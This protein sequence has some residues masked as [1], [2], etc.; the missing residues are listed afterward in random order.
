MGHFG[1]IASL[2][3]LPNEKTLI[4]YV[5]K[6][7]ELNKKGIKKPDEFKPKKKPPLRI[8]GYLTAALKK[9][10]KAR[11]TFGNFSPSHRREYVEWLTE[12]KWEE[13]RAQRL[14]TTIKWLNEGKAR[15]WKYL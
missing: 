12:A 11:K 1:R 15:N 3:D 2:D 13:T 5:R 9:H 4:G 10:A 6:A 8:P 7:A 14:Q